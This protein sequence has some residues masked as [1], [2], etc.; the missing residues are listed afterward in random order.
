MSKISSEIRKWA[1]DMDSDDVLCTTA[2]LYTLADRI[3]SEMA[4]L[5]KTAD[6]VP[7]HVG[8]TA[9]TDDGDGF[10]IVQINIDQDKPRIVCSTGSG[11]DIMRL[12]SSVFHT[13]PDS[14]ERIADELLVWCDYADVDGDACDKPRELAV[15]IRRLAEREGER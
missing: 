3:D 10:E 7:V 4:A 15:R 2:T 11:L 1:D 5:P 13:R 9:Y 12:P 6:G 14:F 8:D